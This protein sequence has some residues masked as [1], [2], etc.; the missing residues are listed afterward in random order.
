VLIVLIA[1]SRLNIRVWAREAL[2]T[3]LSLPILS[4]PSREKS[5]AIS[6]FQFNLAGAP[7]RVAMGL[8]RADDMTHSLHKV[9]CN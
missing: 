5:R 2:G 1:E 7:S 6:G 9:R 4:S 3:A 8:I